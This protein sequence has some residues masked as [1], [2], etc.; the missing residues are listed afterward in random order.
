M[1]VEVNIF[2][3]S[4]WEIFIKVIYLGNEVYGDFDWDVVWGSIKKIFI[5]YFDFVI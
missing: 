5:I 1:Y 4:F 3:S 2:K